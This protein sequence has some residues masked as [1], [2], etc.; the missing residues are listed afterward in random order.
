MLNRTN[1]I[2]VAAVLAGMVIRAP[3]AFPLPPELERASETQKRQYI[4]S[5]SQSGLEEKLRVGEHRYQQRQVYR[6]ALVEEMRRK[7]VERR[8]AVFS[9]PDAAPVAL[10]GEL[11]SRILL[12]V[13]AVSLVAVL[14]AWRHLHSGGENEANWLTAWMR[15]MRKLAPEIAN[16]IDHHFNLLG[17]TPS[18]AANLSG[19]IRAEDAALDQFVAAFRT[20][21]STTPGAS[22]L[23]VASSIECDPLQEF[24]AHAPRFLGKMR[25]LLQE[26]GPAPPNEAP[27][28]RMLAEFQNEVRA[29]KGEAGLSELLPV[30]Q[31]AAALEGLVKQLAD[32]LGNVTPST[33]RTVAGTVDLL[34]D[35][36]RPGLKADLLTNPPLRILAVDD[37]L[38]SRK[39]ILL[40]LKRGL[41]PPELAENGA[42]ALTAASAHAYDV[43]FLD[44]QMPGM[45]GFEVC[46]RIHDTLPNRTT[47]VVF[48]T[49]HRDFEAR[50]QAT[51]S[52]GADL[53]GKPFL[54][55]EITV[56]ALTL[57][58]RGRLRASARAASVCQ[59]SDGSTVIAPALAASSP[60]Q[61]AVQEP[62]EGVTKADLQERLTGNPR[63]DQ[64]LAGPGS[65]VMPPADADSA[66]VASGPPATLVAT[67]PNA[68]APASSCTPAADKIARAFLAGVSERLGELRDLSQ[69]ICQTLDEKAQQ[70]LLVDFYYCLH[71][72]TPPGDCAQGHPALR[73][74]AALEGLLKEL[75]ENPKHCTS[76][77]LLTVDTAVECLSELCRSEVNTDLALNPPIRLLVVDDDPVARRVLSGCLQMEFGRPDSVENGE[78]ALTLAAEKPFDLIFLDVRMPGMDGFTTC[79]RIRQTRFNRLTPVVFVTGYDD[80]EARSQATTSGSSGFITKPASPSEISLTALTFIV[81]AR[82]SQLA[83]ERLPALA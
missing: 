42:A 56:K 19:Q 63:Q 78:A 28:Q 30:W 9:R 29:L 69:A 16:Y 55:F 35:L 65:F 25:E 76:A 53:I 77:A 2:G 38:I 18:T 58:L 47:P 73:M 75:L 59:N 11:C 10:S 12:L 34:D 20:G 79:S 31:M 39:A 66:G 60:T 46:T 48:V 23:G 37:D 36:C 6:R 62:A 21:P 67:L 13:V 50:A 57:G 27:R 1:W 8:Q 4:Q 14:L 71:A 33:L 54:T 70:E 72:L 74:S 49:R 80:L 24:F 32:N 82:L 5:Q 22:P 7:T 44:V 45:D 15:A 83:R 51:V 81:R 3:G 61:N 40:A 64:P 52:G 17:L 41:N 43:I 26:I 68:N